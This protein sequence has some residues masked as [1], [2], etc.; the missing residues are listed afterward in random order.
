M[1][2]TSPVWYVSNILP[3]YQ[4][5]DNSQ[6]VAKRD[7]VVLIVLRLQQGAVE[8]VAKFGP[9]EELNMSAGLFR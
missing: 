8:E 3:C 7:L 6:L 9:V 1:V 5:G 2:Q 4:Y